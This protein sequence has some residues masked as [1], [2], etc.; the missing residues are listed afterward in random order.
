[1][2]TVR[3]ALLSAAVEELTDHGGAGISLRAVARRAGVSHAAPKHHFGDRA[4]LLTAVATEGFRR[5][6]ATQDAAETGGLP[7]LGRAYLDFG[8]REPAV[9]D[10][11]FRAGE[12]R[13]DD[14]ELRSAQQA[15]LAA[16]TRVAPSDVGVAWVFVHGLLTLERDGTLAAAGMDAGELLATFRALV[17]RSGA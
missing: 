14:A 1:V 15:A 12:L 5:L 4:G 17:A 8:R 10:L 16:L 9:Y 2:S 3:Q 13:A 11:M 6:A 7:A